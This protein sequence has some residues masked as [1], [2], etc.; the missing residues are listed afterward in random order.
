MK[1]LTE[2]DPA[3]AKRLRVVL[4]DIDD[5][6]T[7]HGRLPARAYSALEKLQA[8]GLFVVPVTGRPAG[9]CDL[10]ARQWPVDAVVGE[11]G[12][13]WFRHDDDTHRMI[14]MFFRP[15]AERMAD[16]RKL[17]RIAEEVLQNVKGAAIS[18]DQDFRSVD[19]AI[20]F[21]EDVAPLPADD[22]DRIV[23][24]FESHGATAK[25]SSIHVNGW[26]GAHDKLRCSVS[27]L[28]EL[29]GIDPEAHDA[30]L[31][32]G[33]SPNDM[34]MFAHFRHTIGVANV[35]RFADKMTTPPAFVTAAES[36]D[37]FVELADYII[38]AR[39]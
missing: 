17:D 33:D 24:I 23:R 20:D 36:A 10:I 39:T 7:L 13:F 9:W 6:L 25:I 30:V 35:R 5:T 28:H 22:V 8:S 21:C 1:P 34:P 2:F 32:V 38:A 31:F 3:S 11:N 16:R 14:R 4:T 37:G 18:A 19:L 12:A 27:I 29:F 26:Y 15:P